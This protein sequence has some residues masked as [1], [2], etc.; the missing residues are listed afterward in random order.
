MYIQ[1]EA[2]AA[3]HGTCRAWQESWRRV[4][5]LTPPPGGDV[6]WWLHCRLSSH[7]ITGEEMLSFCSGKSQTEN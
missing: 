4:V 5:Y 6:L 7:E 2:V 3:E 1:Q